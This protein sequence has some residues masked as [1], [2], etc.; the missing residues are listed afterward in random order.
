[1]NIYIYFI[2]LLFGK[3]FLSKIRNKRVILLSIVIPMFISLATQVNIGTDY[4]AYRNS[5]LHPDPYEYEIGYILLNKIL[6]SITSNPRILFV[7][8]SFI[9]MFLFY[10]I[11]KKLNRKKIIKNSFLYVFCL[12]SASSLYYLMFNGLRSS[13]AILFF[14]LSIFYFL[15][16][17]YKL[18]IFLILIGSTFHKSIIIVILL[19]L[20]LRKY[21][22]K[23]YNKKKLL[24]LAT[25]LAVLN[26]FRF[27]PKL[28]VFIYNIIPTRFPYRD[29]L[30]SE[31][32]QQYRFVK[33]LGI[34]TYLFILFY[35]L[36]IYFYKKQKENIFL[37]NLGV[38]SI[39]I[40]LLFNDIPIFYRFIDYFSIMETI[41]IYNMIKGTSKKKWAYLGLAI[42]LFYLVTKLIGINKIFLYNNEVMYKLYNK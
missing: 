23:I 37:Y 6:R 3:T 20:I 39:M 35:I 36:S 32:M 42:S 26:R 5:F 17:R 14:I 18:A 25:L 28:A 19:I 4:Y 34:A 30:I 12:C 9:Q 21:L 1:M 2:W 41:I 8:V 27:I 13:I 29:Y 24:I 31:H 16:N 15:S 33:G 11:L 22:F 7:T 10:K 38:L 40:R